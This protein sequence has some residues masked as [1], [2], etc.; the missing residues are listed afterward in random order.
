M[1]GAP[2]P[3]R[4]RSSSAPSSSASTEATTRLIMDA[5]AL[6]QLTDLMRELAPDVVLAH[7]HQDPFNSDHAVASEATIQARQLAS[8]AGVAS[9]SRRSRRLPCCS[10]SLTSRS[11]GFVPTTFLDITP[12][13]ERKSRR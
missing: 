4:P 7:A 9:G 11:C 12:V 6:E 3:R 8:G 1:A 10:S 5:A 13:W 2:K